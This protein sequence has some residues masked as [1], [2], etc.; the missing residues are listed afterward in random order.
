MYAIF[1]TGGKQYKVEE[2]DVVNVEKLTGSIGESIN[3]TEVLAIGGESSAFG[4]PLLEGAS[5]ECEIVDQFKDKK[6]IA[7]KMKKRKS[8]RKTKG[9]RQPLTAVCVTSISQ[10]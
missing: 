9:H 4:T 1:S 6:V 10:N 8:Y 2:G 3:F 7:F 5:V